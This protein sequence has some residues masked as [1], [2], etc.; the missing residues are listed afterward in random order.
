MWCCK[1]TTASM[2]SRNFRNGAVRFIRIALLVHLGVSESGAVAMARKGRTKAFRWSIN[3]DMMGETEQ[4]FLPIGTFK[5]CHDM[6][7]MSP[8]GHDELEVSI[9]RS[10]PRICLAKR[11]LFAT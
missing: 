8:N 6:L 1:I 3:E 9:V 4:A 2:L 7:C 11:S 10:F 5:V